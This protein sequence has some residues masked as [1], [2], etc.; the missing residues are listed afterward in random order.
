MIAR[1]LC[2]ILCFLLTACTSGTESREPAIR[3]VMTQHAE[4]W[5]QGRIDRIPEIYAPDFV[6]HF[7][8]GTVRGPQ[9]IRQRVESL[10]T[11]FP[12][13]NEEVVDVIVEGNRV[14][15]RFVSSGTNLGPFQGKEPTGR[16]IEISEVAIFRVLEDR[17]AEQW[18]YPDLQSMQEQLSRTQ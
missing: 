8:G 6:G 16:T 13:W 7:P 11:A 18:V 15:T 2:L 5:S 10:R 9:G 4:I 1:R 17:I 3:I 12:D 14:V